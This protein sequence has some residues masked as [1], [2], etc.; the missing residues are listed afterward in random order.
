MPDKHEILPGDA[1][2]SGLSRRQFGAASAAVGVAAA[3]T[4]AAAAGLPVSEKEVQIKT[5]DGTCDAFFA[6]PSTGQHPGVLIWT[7]AFG[8]RPA[9]REMAKRLAAEGYA[10]LVPNPFYRLGT[11][12]VVP[13][14]IDFGKPD[15]RAKLMQIMGTVT[16][17]GAAEQDAAA[18]VAFLDAQSQ[19]KKS[20]KIGTQGYCMGGALTMRTAATNANR[21][22][23]GGSFHGGGLATDKPDSPHLLVPKIDAN[24]LIAIA[25]ND[26]K[27]DPAAKDTLREAFKTAKKPAEIEVY[28][29]AN[30]GWCVP[31]SAVYNEPAAEKAWT[32]L[33][34]LYKT[35]LV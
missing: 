14:G 24:Y 13:A 17:A 15:D 4:Q 19:V 18:F 7:D 29:G 33:L 9:F 32:R 10:V 20:A 21:V 22:G 12:P 26:D 2:P 6:H 16:A 5:P 23:A 34:A 30:H 8:L 27:Q 25:D 31:G 28:S 3:A 35:A 11:A 1:T